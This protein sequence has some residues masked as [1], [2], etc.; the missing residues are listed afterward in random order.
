LVS[1]IERQLVA[2][3]QTP[4][5]QARPEGHTTPQPPQLS[6]SVC[7]LLH[8]L[9]GSPSQSAKPALQVAL[10][11][12]ATQAAVVP[13]RTGHTTPQPPQLLTLDVLASQ[14]LAALP[15]QSAVPLAQRKPQ[16][17]AAQTVAAPGRVGHARPHAP[18]LVTL[19]ARFTSQPLAGLRSQSAKPEAQT[20]A[21]APAAQTA[22]AFAPAE[23]ETAHEPQCVG[24]LPV[25]TQAP[26]QR[27][28]GAAQVVAQAPAEHTWPA[29]HA[30]PHAPQW[31]LSLW[32]RTSQPLAALRSQSRKPAAQA[33]TEHAPPEHAEVALGRAH[34]RPQAPQF[35]ALVARFV[36][37][38]LVAAPS[39]SPSEALQR[40]TVQPPATQPLAAA[41]GSEQALPQA[42]QFAGSTAV[43]AQNDPPAMEHETS[44][45]AQVVEH[46][47]R[48]H[49]WPAGHCAPQAPQLAL[50][51]WRLT[52]LVAHWVSPAPQEMAHAP[53]AQAVPGA[54]ALPQAP[55]WALLVRRS[56]HAPPHWVCPDAQVTWQER[57]T[58]MFP[59]GQAAPH[60]PQLSRSLARSAHEAVEPASPGVAQVVSGAAQLVAQTPRLHTWPGAQA[61]P[62][63]PQ[64]AL[65]V[66]A[67]MHEPLQSTCAAPQLGATSPASMVPASALGVTT[68]SLL[69]PAPSRAPI[70]HAAIGMK[71]GVLR[72]F[73]MGAAPRLRGCRPPI[74]AVA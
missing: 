51:L 3:R 74:R 10:H 4:A 61:R 32:P 38:P 67:L 8:P 72:W 18:Q 9:L 58:Q 40:E 47:P 35:A 59:G 31:A 49:T 22:V 7:R 28:S 37:H 14:P 52:Q 25:F 19:V 56:T 27:E 70:S 34:A 26:P 65:S 55:Q 30:R 16:A 1:L 60:A 64:L 69:Q 66:W 36:S 50:S 48:E 21:Q 17:P 53:A 68:G 39:Q 6:G 20:K 46:A 13:G 23:Q 57:L 44:G 43:L 62:Q 73:M 11:A 5:V 63:A 29:G 41:P 12:P 54:Q 45:A 15:S 33:V 42:P 24:S 71:E 2:L